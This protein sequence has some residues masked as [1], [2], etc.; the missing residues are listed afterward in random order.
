MDQSWIMHSLIA[1]FFFAAWPLIMRAS[2]LDPISAGFVLNLTGAV[3][4]LP[5]FL[6]N[7]QATSS[8]VLIGLLIGV[9]SG[10]ANGFGHFD[11]QKVVAVGKI[12]L[13]RA[14][15]VMLVTCIAITTIGARVF[16]GEPISGQKILG[17][18]L[19]ISAIVVLTR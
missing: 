8:V 17:I 10:L 7:R 4:F 9:A 13:G 3:F 6:A 18:G 11:W 19:A 2:G 1:A 15:A 16:Y 5:L 14:T 12:D